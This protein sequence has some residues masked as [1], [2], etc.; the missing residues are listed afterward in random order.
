MCSS[1]NDH[2]ADEIT[3]L[4]SHIHAATCRWLGLVA[5]FDRRGGWGEWGCRSCAHWLSW[6]CGIGPVAARE[7]VRVALR[8]GELPLIRDAFAEGRLSYSQVRALTRIEG[9]ER[10]EDL[11]S[12]ARHATAAQLERLVRAY[13]GVVARARVTA[14]GGPERYVVWDHADDGSVLLRA[15]LPAEEGA[16]VLEALQATLD[17]VGDEVAAP[18]AVGSASA[19]APVLGSASAEARAVGA[20]SRESPVVGSASAESPG[21]GSA[22]AES[23]GAGSASPASP[24]AGSASAESPTVAER[25]AEALLVM[26][27]TALANGPA[28]RTGD[29]YQIVVH[30]DTDELRRGT[31]EAELADGT[32]IAA[33]TA[34]RIA[35]DAA[36]VP[37]LERAGRPLSV[38]R[39]TRS[40][41]PAM[42]RALSSRDRG[43]R[44]PGCSNHRTV[45]AHHI[46]HWANGGRTSLENLVQL[47]RHHHRLL[48]EGGYTVTKAGTGFVFRRPDG[49]RL[50]PAPRK[51]PGSP[52]GLRDAN[53]GARIEPEAIVPLAGGERLDLALGVDALLAFAP[54]EA[55]GI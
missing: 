25:R 1:E 9:V 32:P 24:V 26:A 11:L 6:R 10:E 49:R 23:P 33:A 46:Q 41:P 36:L 21:A 35:C 14:E 2:L 19:E 53:R 38:G 13:R 44:F 54:L 43:C 47:C 45:D 5:E 34:R 20:A 50:M 52:R 30:L 42:R 31:G 16:V 48:H 17:R 22:S 51:P 40:I 3:A 39:K 7:H 29:R 28:A 55:P 8:L 27:E 4:A 37:L 18:R 15:R 12:L